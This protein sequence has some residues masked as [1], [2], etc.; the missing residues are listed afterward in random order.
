MLNMK[1]HGIRIHGQ[2]LTKERNGCYMGAGNSGFEEIYLKYY[3]MV[4]RYICRSVQ[5]RTADAEDLTQEVFWVAYQKWDKVKDHP[6][7]GG[8]LMVVAKNKVMKWSVRPCPL[9]YEEL[10]M[11]DALAEQLDETDS[12]DMVDLCSAVEATLSHEELDILLQYYSYGYTAGEMAKRLGVTE[13]CFK[14]R[15]LRMREKL[16]REI[17]LAILFFVLC[18]ISLIK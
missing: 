11:L 13:S 8:F 7:I 5:N 6:N 18:G 4:Y 2:N 12:Y 3:E 17:D 10:E 15:V 16:R 1:D 9:Y 14:V